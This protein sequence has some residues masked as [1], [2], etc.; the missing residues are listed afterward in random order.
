V[1]TLNDIRFAARLFV[2]RPTVPLLVAGLFAF[3]VGLA[4]GMWAVVDAA[5]LRPLPYREDGALVAV[6]E[7]HPQRGLMAVAPANFFEWSTRIKSLESVAGGYPID[8]SLSS[9]GQP[10]RVSGTKVTERFFDVWGVPPLLGRVFQ[11]TDF[12]REE[13][14]A[15][16]G[17]ALWAAHFGRDFQVIGKVIHVDDEVYTVVGVM[18]PRFRTPGQAE[19][20]IPWKM[21]ADERRERRFHLIS[22]VARLARG[23]LAA[24]AEGELVTAYRRLA[25]DHPEADPQWR[26]RVMPLRD[27]LLGDS[28]RALLVLGSAVAV[29]VVVAWINVA[30]LIVAWL[31]H[32]RQELF[33][34]LAL[35]ASPSRVLR[36]LAVESIVLAGV[37]MTA[38]LVIARLFLHL[39]GAVGVS[40]AMPYDFK[41]EID[42][43]VIIAAA[44]LLL[45]SVA[46]TALPPCILAVRRSNDVVP[47]RTW[48]PRA[49]ARHTSMAAQVAL[50]IVLLAAS[51]C[52]LLGFRS[53]A[54]LTAPVASGVPT[55]AM[56]VSRA[57]SHQSQDVDNRRFFSELLGALAI[58]REVQASAAASYVPP[59]RPLGNVRFSITGRVSST[60]AQT[61]LVS[62]V[63]ASAFKLLG[64]TLLRGRLIEERDTRDTAYAGVISSTL[65]RRY[66][67][68]QN[69]VGEQILLV[70]ADK[71]VTIVGIVADVRQPLD[72]DPRAESVLY[73]SYQQ[74]PWPFMTVMF[75][76]SSDLETA[77]TAVRQEIA[78]LDPTQAA[79]SVS[80][81]RELRTEWL[82]QPRLQTM[83]VSLF[84]AATLL[85][86]MVGLYARAA[87]DVSV[88]AREFAIRQALGARRTDVVRRIT[89][90][91]VGVTG[92]GALAGLAVMPLSTRALRALV[93][94]APPLDSRVVAAIVG[95][96]LL[97]TLGS[98]Y[99]PA[100][101]ASLIE[102]GE[103]LKA[104]H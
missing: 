50:S 84:G 9:G 101:R 86:T 57:E 54:R 68:N 92:V 51:A 52:L 38:G 36:Q 28:R 89:L 27:V 41:P 8:V 81:L 60:E 94:D 17:Y 35:G 22:T 12:A 10:E 16:L 95:I 72:R 46:A 100:R 19:V 59:T 49:L 13:R 103:V 99:W 34:R 104:E 5:I 76:P 77:V 29:L 2:R 21:S 55:F 98:V 78:K 74:F 48:A 3:G 39:F 6:M 64:M 91:A 42:T 82:T 62:A 70:G 97:G 15:V 26:P 24:D 63:S 31:P 67:P 65:S 66:W 85:L 1:D 83:V 7:S 25:I 102:P 18:P 20:W 75:T 40:A 87:H 30:S 88:R 80:A 33:I 45:T 53:L 47:R 44:I 69:P 43:R 23:H 71:P 96:L 79:G 73:L 90:D 32:R 37:G 4:S 93:L 11:P 61:A 58:R 14:I 56:E